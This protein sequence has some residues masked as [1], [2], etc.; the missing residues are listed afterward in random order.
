MVGE[1]MNLLP[2]AAVAR[3]DQA[4]A[5][6]REEL[7]GLGI[8]SDSSAFRETWAVAGLVAARA[9]REI[10]SW[11]DEEAARFIVLFATAGIDGEEVSL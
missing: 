2:V 11:S 7:R 5:A 9:G 6:L 10:G 4:R 3:I 8:E 1:S